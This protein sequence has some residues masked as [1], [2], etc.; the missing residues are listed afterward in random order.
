MQRLAVHIRCVYTVN[1]S[2]C[3]PLILYT[4][5]N[6]HAHQNTLTLTLTNTHTHIH[7]HTDTHAHTRN[8]CS[9]AVRSVVYNFEERLPQCNTHI[10]RT[11]NPCF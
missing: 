7:T 11:H 5:T 8:V 2:S 6:T 10:V 9:Q 4:H 1:G 3:N